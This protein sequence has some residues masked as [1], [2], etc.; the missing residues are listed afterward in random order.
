MYM[1]L[2]LTSIRC[3]NSVVHFMKTCSCTNYNNNCSIIIRMYKKIKYLQLE[4][5]T[6]QISEQFHGLS[7]DL[8]LLLRASSTYKEEIDSKTR[9]Y[10]VKLNQNDNAYINLQNLVREFYLN[11]AQLVNTY[12]LL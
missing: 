2:Y 9:T 5:D 3:T 10:N 6:S 8:P 12:L 4:I 1:Y 11:H 7:I